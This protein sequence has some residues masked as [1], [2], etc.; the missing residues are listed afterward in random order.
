MIDLEKLV[1]WAEEVVAHNDY[2]VWFWG[3]SEEEDSEIVAE[4]YDCFNPPT[5]VLM[6]AIWNYQQAVSLVC[7]Q[8]K[9][10]LLSW[11]TIR[12]LILFE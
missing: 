9:V 7:S 4:R 10:E 5:F 11:L 2:Q 1:K 6:Y 12:E 3:S 8:K